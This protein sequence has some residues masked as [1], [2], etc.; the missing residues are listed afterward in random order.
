MHKNIIE[1]IRIV[2]NQNPDWVKKEAAY[3]NIFRNRVYLR[4]T[5]VQ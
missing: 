2:L 5:S 3:G 1:V 4:R